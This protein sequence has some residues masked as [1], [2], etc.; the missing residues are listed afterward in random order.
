MITLLKSQVKDGKL[1][2]SDGH[3]LNYSKAGSGK[4]LT[5]LNADEVA[6]HSGSLVIAPAI[7]LTMW[8]EEITKFTGRSVAILRKGTDKIEGEPDFVVT[9]Y[10]LAAAS[11]AEA[12]FHHFNDT[13]DD[14]S[15]SLILD[16]AHYLK[17]KDSKRT[18]A[19]FGP[20]CTGRRG[21]FEL[22]DQTFSLTGTPIVRY[23]DDLWAQ[24]RATKPDVLREHDVD[25]YEKFVAK[26]CYTQLKKFH[27]R[28]QPTRVV[29]GNRNQALLN[30]MLFDDCKIIR[31]DIPVEMPPLTTR[32]IDVERAPDATLAAI[33]RKYSVDRIT[34][35]MAE[36]GD[37]LALAWRLLGLSKVK[38]TVEYIAETFTAQR[39]PILVGF[40]HHEVA[41]ALIRALPSAMRV[42]RVDGGTPAK[43]KDAIRDNFNA[44]NIDVLIGQISAMNVS[45]NLQQS[46]SHVIMA[47]DH[48]SPSLIEQFYK[49][50]YRMGQKSHTQLDFM[51]SQ[52]PID[53]ALT[54]VRERKEVSNE[55]TLAQKQVP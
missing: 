24:L 47:E 44:G 53:M 28:Q 18:R 25:T 8:A 17:T 9:T 34:E 7:A 11:Q 19:I 12:L 50:V 30:D 54:R 13:S 22:F 10:A 46:G 27:P 37:E 29:A 2:A 55:Q 39:S 16:E 3:A 35:L 20:A 26:F 48:F 23:N 52:H 15:Q 31:R 49:R 36:D 14:T 4:T 45:W 41:D 33:A 43:L 40:W 21:L 51:K 5:T 32:V 1:M 42:V 6:G 38:G